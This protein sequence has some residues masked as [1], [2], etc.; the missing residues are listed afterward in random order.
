MSSKMKI[1]TS[2]LHPGQDP[3]L[4]LGKGLEPQVR[5]SF[6]VRIR[7]KIHMRT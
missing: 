2:D 5:I 1:M 6:R 7:I 4:R 3:D